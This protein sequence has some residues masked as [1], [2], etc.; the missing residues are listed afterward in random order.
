[1]ALMLGMVSPSL[2]AECP[3]G[4]DGPRGK[5]LRIAGSGDRYLQGADPF[6]FSDTAGS[7]YAYTTN[8]PGSN[9]PVYR[10]EADGRWRSLGDA[11]PKLPAWAKRGRTWAPETMRLGDGKYVLW[12]TAQHGASGKQCIGRALGDHAEGPYTDNSS[13]P[14]LCDSARE[15]SIDPS[16]FRDDDGKLYLLWKTRETAQNGL[17]TTVWIAPLDDRGT[18]LH[19]GGTPILTNTE[20]WEGEHVEAPTLLKKAGRYFLL[21][22]AGASTPRGYLSAWAVADQ[23]KGPYKKSGKVLLG[24][25]PCMQGAG[26][27]SVVADPQGGYRIYF[28]AVHPERRESRGDHARF[29]DSAQLCFSGGVPVVQDAEC[30]R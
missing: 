4:Y 30:T 20:P 29:L 13:A 1:L 12:Y 22:S 27:Q 19:S 7:S 18:L 8:R 25:S 5:A 10:L 6:V 16:P 9:V 28:H 23:L 26:H 24:G 14:F 11:L 15:T 2:A 21:Y 17:K 3:A